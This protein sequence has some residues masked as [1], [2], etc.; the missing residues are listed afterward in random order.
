[1]KLKQAIPALGSAA[2]L[3]AALG[4]TML[5]TSPR[6]HADSNGDSRIQIGLRI[7]PVKLKMKGLNPDLVG[8]GSFIVNAEADCN[9]CH[10]NPDYGPEYSTD[11]TLVGNSPPGVVNRAA[12]L[13]GGMYFATFP[14]GAN[15]F[16]RNLT[17]DVSG[18]PEGGHTLQE[19]INI[20]RTGH[21][22]D[23]A[24]PPCP[25]TGSEGCI[26]GPP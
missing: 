18:K 12:Y 15:I 19:F 25:A 26:L 2:V 23:V 9:G 20:M 13:G 3:A 10:T 4:G 5:I 22:Y 14:G 6:V 1:M 11:P 7:A 17:P 24:H 21:D 16:S 8:I